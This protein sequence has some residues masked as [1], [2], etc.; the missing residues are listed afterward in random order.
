MLVIIIISS[1]DKENSGKLKVNFSNPQVLLMKKNKTKSSTKSETLFQIDD[2]GKITVVVE[3]VIVHHVYPFSY[4]AVIYTNKGNYIIYFDNTSWKLPDDFDH[5]GGKVFIGE[6]EEGDLI[7]GDVS[8][9]RKGTQTI[10]KLQ[11]AL[12]GPSV[13][14]L[15]G[16]FAIISG[17]TA[18]EWIWQIFNTVD[19]K[20][21]RA[22]SN[23][24]LAL[25]KEK[26]LSGGQLW[27][28]T[29]GIWYDAVA[30]Y[31]GDNGIYLKNGAA[32]LGCMSGSQYYTGVGIIYPSGDL[33]ILCND[34]FTYGGGRSFFNTGDYFIVKEFDK[35]SVVKR[36]NLSKT[37]I[38]AEY[39]VLAIA[40][41]LNKVYFIS[42]DV[43][44]VKTVG[45]FSL[46][47]NTVTIFETEDEYEDIF[48]I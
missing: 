11:T 18:G 43:Y 24:V 29:T 41:S 7:F 15:S 19:T 28:M 35:I 26:A 3:G 34:E 32:I 2:K 20:R 16:N 37:E 47:D 25:S 33:E 1:C 31:T 38:L 46:D 21:Y 23:N 9:I 48:S 30:G 5:G 10:S 44:G 4:G 36:G 12:D 45:F 6:N 13:L 22:L 39:N 27:D 17:R 40:V 14:E 8:I 42:E